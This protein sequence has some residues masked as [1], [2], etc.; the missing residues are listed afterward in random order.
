MQTAAMSEDPAF[1]KRIE[2]RKKDAASGAFMRERRSFI[3][4][5]VTFCS[6]LYLLSD[7]INPADLPN[8]ELFDRLDIPS[9]IPRERAGKIL[10]EAEDLEFTLRFNVSSDLA[11]R[12]FAVNVAMN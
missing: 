9:V 3:T 7:G 12:T 1:A 11:L 4:A 2:A 8:P 5:I 10:K 6:Q